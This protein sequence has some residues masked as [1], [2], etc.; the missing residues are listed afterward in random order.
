[1]MARPE[2]ALAQ[3]PR[4]LVEIQRASTTACKEQC[5]MISLHSNVPVL[6]KEKGDGVILDHGYIELYH[7]SADES[8]LV[9]DIGIASWEQQ[10]V[11]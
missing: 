1:M 8:A 2:A 4:T 7:V 10:H 3:P 9:A 5:A 6:L 11:E